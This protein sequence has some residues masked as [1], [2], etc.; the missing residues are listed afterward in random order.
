MQLAVYA[1]D[2]SKR[3]AEVQ[4]LTQAWIE[5]R[6]GEIFA[7]LGPNGAGKTTFLSVL[8]GLLIPD[9]GE[10]RMLRAQ[11]FP[12][13]GAGP[14]FE[15]IGYASGESRFHY[16]L[17]PHDVLDLYALAYG[18][19]RRERRARL[20]RLMGD[21]GLSRC[22]SRRFTLLSSGEKMRLVLAK[23]L[24][25]DPDLLLLDEPTVGLDPEGAM[26]LRAEIRRLNQ[27]RGVT[28]LLTSHYMREVEELAGRV[29]FIRGGRIVDVGPTQEVVER[30]FARRGSVSVYG[31][32]KEVEKKLLAMGFT[33]R[34][35]RLV[36]LLGEGEDPAGAAEA[37]SRLGVRPS[38]ID[39]GKPTLE[40][41]FLHMAREG[42]E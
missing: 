11:V 39:V 12:E 24:V 15:R 41:Y 7:L 40:D 17:T 20:K 35:S 22:A 10:V 27:E 2:V 8:M 14:P 1:K 29:A 5:V 38:Q 31:V 4:A 25:N 23:A 21:M 6:E 30:A 36:K 19:G 13:T 26:A 42:G 28:I 32:G 18:Q 33:P 34:G 3:F 37:A 16:A 9:S